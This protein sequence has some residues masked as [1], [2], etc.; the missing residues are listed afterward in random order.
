MTSCRTH[1]RGDELAAYLMISILRL[2]LWRVALVVVGL[3]ALGI[4]AIA[5]R[6]TGMQR[7]SYSVAAGWLS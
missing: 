3:L 6:R 4:G 7:V 5:L 2:L 1:G